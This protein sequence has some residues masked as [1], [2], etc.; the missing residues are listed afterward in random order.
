MATYTTLQ[1]GSKGDE[2][3]KLQQSLIDAGYNVGSSGA[4][5]I[6]G[7]NTAAAVKAYQKANGLS[8]DG[9][10]GNQTLGKLYGGSAA[11]ATQATPTY[12]Y[13]EFK[14]DPYEKSD[15]VKQA[16]AMLQQQASQKPGEYQSTW[17]AQLNDTLNKI[18]NREEFSYDLNGDALYQQYK[19]Q[20][21]T[22]GQMAMMDT[23]GQAAA[24]TGGYG[25][26]YAQ[27]VGQQAYQGYLQQLN[28]KVPELYQLALSQYNQE[29]QNLKDQASLLYNQEQQEYSR[30]RDDVSDYYTELQRLTERADTLT[31]REYNEWLDKINLD[32]GIHSDNQTAGYQAQQDAYDKAMSMLGLGVTPDSNVLATAGISSAEAQAIIK[33]VNEQAAASGSSGSKSSNNGDDTGN[34]GGYDTHGYTTEQIKSLQRAAGIT[35]DGI[36]GKQ[37]EAAYQ[38]GI[39]PENDKPDASLY[40]DWDAGDWES[41]FAQIR[42]SEGKAAAQEELKYFT[43]NGLIPQK[44]VNYG[45]IGARGGSMGH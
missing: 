1:N 21:T 22:Q 5:G 17:Q 23:M 35:V 2:V 37:T 11:T 42:Q 6:Y 24:M 33:K 20:Y 28:D 27:S 45:A 3:K 39:R 7:N 29:G 18:L 44:F 13:D 43:D 36:W 19:D 9:I 34:K 14:Y 38:K 40:K 41:Y 31:E 15:V 26:S 4:D 25:N 10:A 32:Y 16:E 8:V 12:K 30:Y